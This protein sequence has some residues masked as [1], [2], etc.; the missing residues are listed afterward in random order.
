MPGPVTT[1]VAVRERRRDAFGAPPL[2]Q[3]G[4]TAAV[5]ALQQGAGNRAVSRLLGGGTGSARR[6]QREIKVREVDFDPKDQEFRHGYINEDVFYPA[7]AAALNQD[8]AFSGHK[9]KLSAVLGVVRAKSYD[10]RD[11][12]TIT[13][14][15]VTDV[16]NEF[17]T[18]GRP[19][20][21]AL[22]DKL[23][24]HLLDALVANI[25]ADYK[26]RMDP[27]ELAGFD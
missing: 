19:I 3:A 22:A 6:L 5:L 16:V 18:Q 14:K 4:A 24:K 13:E 21:G 26:M 11:I 9:G 2:R 10:E 27:A 12:H 20:A 23:R 7:L 1:E 15:I 17:S 25:R 8:G